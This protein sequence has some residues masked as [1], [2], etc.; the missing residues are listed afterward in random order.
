M[1]RDPHPKA[2]E[3]NVNGKYSEHTSSV[4]RA[5]IT[6]AFARIDQN[7]RDEK[8]GQY[9]EKINTHPTKIGDVPH[10]RTEYRTSRRAG[11]MEYDDRED[12]DSADSIEPRK[13]WRASRERLL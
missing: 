7:A 5:E 13:V 6:F 1:R 8:S 2:K 11:D 10:D 12:G 4:K 3:S 9:E